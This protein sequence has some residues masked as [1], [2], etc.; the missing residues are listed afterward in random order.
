[1]PIDRRKS[2]G[3]IIREFK[4]GRTYKRTKSRFGKERADAQAIA[5]ALKAKG[6]SKRK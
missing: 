2:I 1:M 6:R 4:K 5:I 3:D